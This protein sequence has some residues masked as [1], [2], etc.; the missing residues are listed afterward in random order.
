MVRDLKEDS[1][2]W[3]VERKRPG[4]RISY[5]DSNTANRRLKFGASG[6][7]N[8]PDKTRALAAQRGK[9]T[10]RLQNESTSAVQG[11]ISSDIN[12]RTGTAGYQQ[13]SKSQRYQFP[14][15][16]Q[17]QD[18]RDNSS[19]LSTLSRHEPQAFGYP[20]STTGHGPSYQAAASSH[21]SAE[22][23]PT[24]QVS[25]TTSSNTPYIAAA[26]AGSVI[27]GLVGMQQAFRS[28]RHGPYNPETTGR[29]EL[30]SRTVRV[31]P[32]TQEL[33]AKEA[34]T[35]P[36]YERHAP[37]SAQLYYSNLRK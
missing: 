7:P 10:E 1:S 17:D 11:S 15:D 18:Q 22:H 14:Q 29:Q 32:G 2:N 34:I 28:N 25:P 23:Q 12:S 5:A 9:D 36:P 30:D 13:D 35:P 8:I 21:R 4:T 26:A 27:V 24:P 33:E 6:W 3:K 19:P 16:P 20:I 37:D 31:I